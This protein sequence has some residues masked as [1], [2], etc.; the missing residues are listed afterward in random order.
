MPIIHETSFDSP[1]ILPELT[2]AM[3]ATS[4]RRTPEFTWASFL[5]HNSVLSMAKQGQAKV[6]PKPR[7]LTAYHKKPHKNEPQSL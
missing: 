4:V 6:D 3:A 5:L 7:Y 1:S 2:L